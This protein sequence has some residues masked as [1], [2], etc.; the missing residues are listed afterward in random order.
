[1]TFDIDTY[2]EKEIDERTIQQGF[3]F[4]LIQNILPRVILFSD[5]ELHHLNGLQATFT[6]NIS[7]LSPSNMLKKWSG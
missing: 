4:E 5:E 1:M 2:F 6:K 3:N 7:Q